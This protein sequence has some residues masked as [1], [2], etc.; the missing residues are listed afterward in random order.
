MPSW[1]GE[2]GLSLIEHLGPKGIGEITQS[3]TRWGDSHSPIQ[4][5]ITPQRPPSASLPQGSTAAGRITD[6]SADDGI[7]RW[8]GICVRQASN[9]MES[10]RCKCTKSLKPATGP[11]VLTHLRGCC[12]SAVL[13]RVYHDLPGLLFLLSCLSGSGRSVGF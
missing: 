5:D 9:W 8:S 7:P 10:V 1:H 12:T 3:S 6:C 13:C 11:P 2:A 4:V